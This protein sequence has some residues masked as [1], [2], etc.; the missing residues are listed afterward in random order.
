MILLPAWLQG[1]DL[2]D[3]HPW[4][5]GGIPAS[6]APVRCPAFSPNQCM[7]VSQRTAVSLP[8]ITAR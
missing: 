4:L 7:R 6:A 1:T 2:Q 3:G 5:L 8:G